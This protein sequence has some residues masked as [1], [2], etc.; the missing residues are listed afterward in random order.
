MQELQMAV[1]NSQI[2]INQNDVKT[3]IG[4]LDDDG[5]DLINY[6]EFLAATIKIDRKN[7][8]T[9]ERRKALFKMFDIM[10]ADKIQREHIGKAFNKIGKNVTEE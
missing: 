3:I 9:T 6:T 5:N 4:N 2:I 8:L 1:S 10:D 7:S